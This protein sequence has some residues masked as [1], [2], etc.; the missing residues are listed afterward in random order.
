[1]SRFRTRDLLPLTPLAHALVRRGTLWGAALGLGVLGFWLL[2]VA[3]VDE[4]PSGAFVLLSSELL[5]T[6]AFV[7][8]YAASVVAALF[9]GVDAADR[10]RLALGLAPLVLGVSAAVI[11]RALAQLAGGALTAS[12]GALLLGAGCTAQVVWLVI[13]LAKRAHA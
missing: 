11:A 8:G 12:G 1:M 9:A 10:Y 5:L 13:L 4:Q 7:T 2:T 6:W 3:R